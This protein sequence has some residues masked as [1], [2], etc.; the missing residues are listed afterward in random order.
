VDGVTM[1]AFWRTPGQPDVLFGRG[2]QTRYAAD[3]RGEYFI[4]LIS[5]PGFRAERGRDRFVFRPGDIGVWDPSAPHSGRAFDPQSG[6]W[7]CQ[8]LV[9]EDGAFERIAGG[10]PEFPDPLVRDRRLAAV[11]ARMHRESTCASSGL[12]RD[13]ALLRVLRAL[14]A[15]AP[16]ARPAPRQAHDQAAVRRARDYLRDNAV[17]N[18]SLTELSGVGGMPPYEMVRSFRRTYGVPP[19][20]YLIGLR[21]TLARRMLERGVGAGEAATR[22]GFHDQSHLHRHFVRNFG[23]TPGAYAAAVVSCKDVQDR[24]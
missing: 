7:T 11:F 18:V 4:G 23:L 19:H 22:A 17:R 21:L 9:V 5:G 24:V 6:A 1:P 14:A 16:G 3:P 15:R 8:L 20:G 12:E 13:T 10:L 2:V